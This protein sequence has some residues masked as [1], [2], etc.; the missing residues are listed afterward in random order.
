MEYRNNGFYFLRR[1]SL[2]GIARR[3]LNALPFF[4]FA[5][6]MRPL[7]KCKDILSVRHHARDASQGSPHAMALDPAAYGY[8]FHASTISLKNS[9]LA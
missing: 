8:S 3:A 9:Q 2:F 5:F 6:T 1:V 7:G 4:F